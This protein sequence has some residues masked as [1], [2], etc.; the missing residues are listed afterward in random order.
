MT[1]IDTP[2]RLPG[3]AQPQL[4]VRVPLQPGHL[5][6]QPHQHLAG[7]GGPHR[8][9]AQQQHPP[10]ALLQRL[11]PLAHRRGRHVQRGGGRV[12]RPLVD[13]REQRPYLVQRK[14][15]HHTG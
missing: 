13:H 14:V 11:D 12:E 10:G 4:R 9:G 8:A 1:A 7:L 6:G 15:L 5:P 2:R 3:A